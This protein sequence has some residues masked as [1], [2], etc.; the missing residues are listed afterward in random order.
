MACASLLYQMIEQNYRVLNLGVIK[1][2][3]GLNVINVFV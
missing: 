1:S 3:R 2:L